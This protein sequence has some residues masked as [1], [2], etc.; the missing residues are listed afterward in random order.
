MVADDPGTYIFAYSAIA[1]TRLVTFEINFSDLNKIPQRARDEM[2]AVAMTRKRMMAQRALDL[3]KNLKSIQRN[4]KYGNME[5]EVET[6]P[7]DKGGLKRARLLA[8]K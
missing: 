8:N 6:V 3:Y 4:L 7:G 5:S 1:K 2:C